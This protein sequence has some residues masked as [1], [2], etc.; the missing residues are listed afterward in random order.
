MPAF[1]TVL[2][3]AKCSA[4]GRAVDREVQFR[5]GEVWQY[6]YVIGDRLEWGSGKRPAGSRV[7]VDGYALP[8]PSCSF[9]L[10]ECEILVRDDMLEG[11]RPPSGTYHFGSDDYIVLDEP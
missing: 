5:F 7:L 2:W 10:G 6:D 8:C 9:E 4:C 1:N 11:V 3:T